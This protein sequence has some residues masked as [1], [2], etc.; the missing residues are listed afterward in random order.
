MHRDFRLQ[1]AILAL[2]ALC[3]A[4]GAAAQERSNVVKFGV[5]RYTTHSRTN[6]V[7]GPG[8]P[9]GADASTGDATTV[10]FEYER[11][12]GPNWGIEAALG[13]PPRIHARATGSVSYLGDDILSAKN[14]SPTLFVNYHFGAPDARW[15]PYLGL[16]IN[17]TRFT[18]ATSRL[19]S[20][21]EL[22]D[23]VG[24]AGKAGIEYVLSP[25]WSLFASV[26]AI[27]VKSD[28]V[29][30]GSTVLQTTIDFRPILYTIGTSYRF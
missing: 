12:F 11:L 8:V 7:T 13:V 25:Q 5:V 9:A 30:S 24:P 21:V 14:V 2:A 29:A 22:S 1:P 16:G 3:A 26:T 27:K 17:Y 6:G 10:A 23:S 28:L 19:A 18:G 4:G 15:R 20:Q